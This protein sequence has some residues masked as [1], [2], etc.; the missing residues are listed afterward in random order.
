MT[1][2]SRTVFFQCSRT[3]AF[4]FDLSAILFSVFIS[5]HL[6]LASR[7]F[8][9]V[10][11]CFRSMLVSNRFNNKIDDDYKTFTRR[12]DALKRHFQEL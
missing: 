4:Y 11:C 3:L 12:F 1:Q 8:F 9:W 6:L 5:G 10:Y 7:W 2:S